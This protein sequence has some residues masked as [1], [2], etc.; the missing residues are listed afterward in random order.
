MTK[1]KE[2]VGIADIPLPVSDEKLVERFVNSALKEFTV[3][4]PRIET[5]RLGESDR[6]I[7]EANVPLRNNFIEYKIPRYVYEGTVSNSV[8]SV[9]RF[10]VLRNNGYA[11]MYLPHGGMPSADSVI[12]TFA[13]VG[14]AAMLCQAMTRTMT[15]QFRKP[16]KLMVFDG[17][18]GGYYEADVC[19]THDPSLSTVPDTAFTNLLELATLDMEEYLYN[20][21]KRKNN[22]DLGIGSI[23]LHIDDWQG[24]AADKKA[25][26][27]DWDD[28]N[29]V[30]LE[31]IQ[32][33]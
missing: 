14:I 33:W 10:E 32:F 29:S 31:C 6:I 13:D 2:D 11:N 30:D 15:F 12:E 4:C 23:D 9:T 18:A 26:L 25:L 24:A 5:I 17:W 20:K 3:R 21:L 7:P 8:L 19:L 1:V 22:L 27:K 28:E 16:D